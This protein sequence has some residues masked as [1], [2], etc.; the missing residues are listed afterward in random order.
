MYQEKGGMAVTVLE[1][2]VAKNMTA[3]CMNTQALTEKS[4]VLCF[5]SHTQFHFLLNVP[6]SMESKA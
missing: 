4:H 6:R 5:S 3:H 2:T 1:Y